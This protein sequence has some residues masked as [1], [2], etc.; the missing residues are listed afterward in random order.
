MHCEVYCTGGMLRRV[1]NGK[2]VEMQ[3]TDDEQI[4][5][6]STDTSVKLITRLET[7]I[8]ELQAVLK[9]MTDFTKEKGYGDAQM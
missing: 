6:V 2:P 9:T 1:S 7:T 3:F 5:S 8:S 4:Y